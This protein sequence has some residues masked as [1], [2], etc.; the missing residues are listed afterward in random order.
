[1]QKTRT[2]L[3]VVEGLQTTALNRTG[4]EIIVLQTNN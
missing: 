4:K 1:L 3:P 2:K